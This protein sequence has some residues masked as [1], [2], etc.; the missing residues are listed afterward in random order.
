[1]RTTLPIAAAALLYVLFAYR[2]GW[3]SPVTEDLT[4][5][6]ILVQVT[7]SAKTLQDVSDAAQHTARAIDDTRKLIDAVQGGYEELARYTDDAFLRDFKRDA[8]RHYPGLEL[9]VEGPS[10]Q[11]LRYWAQGRPRTP[12]TA[13]EMISATFQDFS[14]AVKG[15]AKDGTIDLDRAYLYRYE[16]AGALSLAEE[17]DAW[18]IEATRSA[19]DLAALAASP[20]LNPGQAQVLSAKA[21]ALM[22][23]QNLH[24]VRLMARRVRLD[25]I[26]SAMAWG[27]SVAARNGDANQEGAR[28]QFFEQSLSPP[29]LMQFSPPW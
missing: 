12:A 5:F 10:S 13:Y 27:D 6:E 21:Q 4:L 18:A 26:R 25:G 14:E 3:A 22:A 24:I 8:Y 17:S 29:G 15:Q 16:G 11:K 20:D 19:H 7:N 23:V 9:L 2:P 1:M 28:T